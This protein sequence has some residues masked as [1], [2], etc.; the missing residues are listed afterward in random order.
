MMHLIQS[1]GKEWAGLAQA[2][3]GQPIGWTSLAQ[4]GAQ[5]QMGWVLGFVDRVSAWFGR[6][7]VQLRLTDRFLSADQ[8]ELARAMIACSYSN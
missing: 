7:A 1:C 8:V 5:N 4:Q 6:K 3:T 2:C